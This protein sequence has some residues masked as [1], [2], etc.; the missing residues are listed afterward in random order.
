MF[1]AIPLPFHIW[2][3]KYV[4][5]MLATFPLV[6]AIIGALWWAAGLLFVTVS[7]PVMLAAAILTLTP[8]FIAGFMHLD[9][10]MDTSDAYL[11]RRSLE[12]KLRILKDPNVGAFAVI[13]LAVLLL[14]Q[15]AAVYTVIENADGSGRYLKLLIAVSVVSRSCAALSIF[16]LRH[17]PQSS[18]A[19]M[20]GE[21]TGAP[22]KIFIV[23][24]GLGAI[25]LSFVYAGIFGL[26]VGLAV[27]L[28]YVW[29][30]RVVYKDFKGVSGDLLGY[31]LVISE[32]CGLIAL[33]L[34][35]GM[36]VERWF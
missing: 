19:A 31:S 16:V 21:K 27:I 11:S 34:L 13:M 2:E 15:F 8:F 3:Q 9:G 6:G 24:M 32:L 35:Q 29:S 5:V 14:L 7:L 26:I 30:M 1:C 18:Y 23:A 17:I 4:T 36:E 12:D 20:L 22:P 10:Y 33:A 25:A 28:G